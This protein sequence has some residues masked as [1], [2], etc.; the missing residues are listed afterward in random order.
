MS[1][2]IKMLG[3][4]MDVNMCKV[5]TGYKMAKNSWKIASMGDMTILYIY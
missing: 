5:G 3:A 2:Y 1:V 4:E